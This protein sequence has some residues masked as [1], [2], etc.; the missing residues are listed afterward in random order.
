MTPNRCPPARRPSANRAP[1]RPEASSGE[2]RFGRSTPGGSAARVGGFLG[3]WLERSQVEERVRCGAH[4]FRGTS[5][6]IQHALA[7]RVEASKEEKGEREFKDER[8]NARPEEHDRIF[9]TGDA[10]HSRKASA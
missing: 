5:E 1:A 9:D 4:P 3:G 2:G 10:V 7:K 6:N 8:E